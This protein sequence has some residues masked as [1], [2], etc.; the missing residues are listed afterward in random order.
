MVFE[1]SASES[2]QKSK[3]DILSI[4]FQHAEAICTSGI[5][6]NSQYFFVC[7]NLIVKHSSGILH[8]WNRFWRQNSQNLLN[9]SYPQQ[10]LNVCNLLSV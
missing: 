1:C 6:N 7:D 10:R 2:F 3:T 8:L 5:G 9:Q 4:G